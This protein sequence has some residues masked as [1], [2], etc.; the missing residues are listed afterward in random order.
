MQ[1]G[2]AVKVLPGAAVAGHRLAMTRIGRQPLQ[3]LVLLAGR[4]AAVL[5]HHPAGRDIRR[6][7]IIGNRRLHR[8]GRGASPWRWKYAA[9][10][11]MPM[12]PWTSTVFSEMPSFCAISFCERP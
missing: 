10:L 8:E 4:E 7:G 2:E 3:E 9:H 5:A 6:I 11:R 1:A 12:A